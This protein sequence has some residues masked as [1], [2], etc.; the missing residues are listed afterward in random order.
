MASTFQIL[1]AAKIIHHGGIIA[2]PTES[3][4]GLGCD[5]L[6]EHAVNRILQLKQRPVEKGLILLASNLQQLLAFVEISRDEEKKISDF[7]AP[8]TWL[9]KKSIQTPSWIS[10]RHSKVAIRISQHP[11]VQQLCQQLAQPIVS[12]S[13]NPSNKKPANSV[14]QARHYFRNNIDMY[15]NGETGPLKNPTPISDLAN[16]ELIRH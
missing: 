5:P 14:L 3:V 1:Q 9:V 15:L 8:M 2:Y 7:K 11:L 12:T 4:Y 6:S 10:G 13:A 16:N